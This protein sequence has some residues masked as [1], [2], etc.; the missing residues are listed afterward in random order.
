[1]KIVAIVFTILISSLAFWHV[2]LINKASGFRKPQIDSVNLI[3]KGIQTERLSIKDDNDLIGSYLKEN[4]QHFVI[5][6]YLQEEGSAIRNV[7][8]FF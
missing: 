5:F 1:M 8:I 3:I 7:P 6:N 2:H 4:K